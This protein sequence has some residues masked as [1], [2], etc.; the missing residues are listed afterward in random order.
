MPRKNL[1]EESPTKAEE[2]D[3]SYGINSQ[4]MGKNYNPENY[5]VKSKNRIKRNFF[6]F[7]G[8]YNFFIIFQKM[9]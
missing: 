1:F 5:E 3:K 8:P 7:S 6:R 9:G 4:C 2:K